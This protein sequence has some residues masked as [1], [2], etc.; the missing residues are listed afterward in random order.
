MTTHTLPGNTPLSAIAPGEYRLGDV[1]EFPG[2][3]SLTV[4]R[5]WS[6]G[7]N[8]LTH[9]SGHKG[10]CASCKHEAERWAEQNVGEKPLW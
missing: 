8:Y 2:L 3:F 7:C 6:C 1:I 4:C 10:P 5:C 9:S